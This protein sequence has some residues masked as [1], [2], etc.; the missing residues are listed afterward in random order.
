M[1]KHFLVHRAQ[2]NKEIEEENKRL[3]AEQAERMRQMGARK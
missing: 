3:R 2:K 1:L